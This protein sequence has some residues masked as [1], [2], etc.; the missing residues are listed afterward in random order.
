MPTPNA[1]KHYDSNYFEWQR[2]IGGFG[3]KANALKI[4][5]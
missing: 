1:S 5:L 2:K 4:L 3:G